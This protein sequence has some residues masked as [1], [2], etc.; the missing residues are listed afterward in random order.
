MPLVFKKS[1]RDRVDNITVLVDDKT[2]SSPNYFRVS[3][4]PQI[5]TKGKNLIK[6]SGH[7]T[8]LKEDTQIFIDVRDSNGNP[9]YYEIPDYIEDDKSRVISIWVYHDK[10]DDNT[11]NG[12]A[13]IT[14]VGVA[15]NDVDG[16]PVPASYKNKLNV[17][18]QTKVNV[19]RDRSSTTPI[20]FN[21][22]GITPSLILSESIESYQNQPQSGNDLDLTVQEGKVRYIF[23]GKTPIV[24]ITDGTTFNQE[25]QDSSILLSNFTTPATP[26]SKEEPT[27]LNFFSG[28]IKR[29][30]NTTTIQ[31]NN[32]YTA[33]FQNR[34]GLKHTYDSV[35][36]SDYKIEYFRTSSNVSTENQRS[37]VN[38]SFNNVDPIVGVVDKIKVLQKS[39]GL[40]GEFELLNEVAVPF[41]S[42]FSVKIPMP[43]EN[44]QDPKLLK[45]QYLNSIGEI[46]R[47]ETNIGPF[48][49]QGGNSYIGGSQNLISGS[50]FVS[51]TVGT[52]IELGGASSGFMRSVGFEGQTSA[53]L[54]KAPGGFVIYSGSGNLQM[55][56]DT[57]EGVGMQFIGDNDERHLIFTTANGGL[58]DVKT[59]KFFIGTEN[60]QFISGSD[61]NIE[62]SSSLFH[63]DP[64]NNLLTIG[65]DA[66][67][68]AGLSADRIFTPAIID[69][70]PSNINNASS[71]ITQD[72]FA[73]FTSA[74]IAGF[75]VNESEIKSADE[76]LRLKADGNITASKVLLQGGT[77]TD[78]VTILGSVSANSIQTP[79]TIGGNPST[80]GN[81]S[82]SI[83]DQGFASFKSA[84]IGGWDITPNTIQ[85]SNLVMRPAGILQT[86]DF[87]SGVKGWKISSEGNGTAEFEN[88]R[89]RGT[90][91]TTTFEKESVNAVGGQLWVTNA[92][93]LTGSNITST[94]T[95]MSVK[96][97]SGFAVG[98]ILLAKKVDGTGFQTEYLL[99]ESASIDGDNSG[100]EEVHGRIYV[101][102]AYGSGQQGEFVGDLASSAQTYDEGQVIV[103]TGLSGSGYIKMNANPKDTATPYMDIVERTGSG[104]FDAQLKVRLGDLSG[105]ANSD[106]VFG[107]PNPG[108]GLATD[109]V[110]L[111]G[112]IIANTGSIAGIKMTDGKLF[113]GNGSYGNSNTGFYVDSD[114]QFSLGN[115]LVWNPTTE[116]LVIRGQLQLSDGSDVGSALAEATS[117]NTSKTVSLGASSY[118]ITFNSLGNQDPAGQSITLTATEQ[119]HVG[120][121]Y[122]EFRKGGSLQGARGTSNTFVADQ[123]SE[124]PSAT[125][126]VTYEVKTFEVASGGSQI[127]S[128]TLTLFGVQAGASGSDGTSGQDGVDAVTAFLT[129]EAHT[130]AA[131][132]DKSIVSLTGGSTD[133][134]V[135]EGI[136]DKTTSYSYSRSSSTSVSSSISSNTVTVTSMAHDSGSI[137][138]TATSAST[139]LSKTMS[140]SKAIAGQT[141]SDGTDGTDGTDGLDGTSAKT[142]VAS[143]DSQ[144]MA[145]DDSSDTSATPTEVVFSFNQQNLNAAIGSSDITISTAGG[146][147]TNFGFDNNSVT[148]SSGKHSGISSGSIS[149]TGALNSGGLNSTKSNFPV[150]IS[151]TKDGLSDSIKLF[152]VE[153]GADGTAGADGTDAV[154]T[155]LTNESHTFTA[156]SDGTIISFIGGSTDMEV[157]EGVT[158][159][160]ANYTISS[161][162]GLGVT[163]TDSGKTVTISGMTH[164]SGSVTITA[165][166]AS[167]SLSKSMSLTKSKQGTAGLA[168]SDA[169][170][171]TVSSDSQVFSFPS[172][173]SSTAI[174][175]DILITINQQNLSGTVGGGDFTIV[176]A[177]GSTLSDP[178]L[179]ASV[180]D[181]SGQVTGTITFSGTASGDKTKLPLTITVSKDSLED[182][183]KIFGIDGGNEGQDGAAGADAVT[184][185]LTNESHTF[186][187]DSSGSIASFVGGSTNMEIFEGI[188]NK[189]SLYTI[190]SS[191]SLGVTA[192]DNSNTVTIGGMNH[193]SGSVTITAT[194]ASVSLSKIMSLTKARQ[195]SDGSD[196]TSAK[197]LIGS[198]DSQVFAFTDSTDTTSEPEKVFFSYQQQNLSAAIV[199][200]DLTITTAGGSNITNFDF[201]NSDISSGTGIVSGSIVFSQALN[202]GGVAGTKSN[203][204]ITVS[205]TKDGLQDS[206]RVFKVE[207]GSDGTDGESARTMI[208]TNESHTFA[209]QPNGTIISFTGG[210]TDVEVFTGTSNTTSDYSISAAS[211]TS[212]SSSVSS[213]TVTV[214]SMG[215]D[216]GSVVVTATSAS[217]NLQKLFSLTKAKQGADGEDGASGDKFADTSIS[218]TINLSTLNIDDTITFTADTGL[219]WTAGLTAVVAYDGSNSITG[220]VNSYNS[221]NGSM[222]INVDSIVG[223][224][225]QTAWTLNLGGTAGPQGVSGVSAKS[226]VAST[227]S[228]V[229]SFL[230]ASDSTAE[231]TSIIFSFNQQNLNDSIGSSDVTITAGDGTN[232]TGF[233]F[234]NNSVTDGTG[235][236]SGS[237]S[238]SSG[239]SAGGLNSDKTKLPVTISVTNDS[240]TD[241]IKVFKVEGGTSGTDGTDGSDAVTTFLTNEAHTFA[242]QNDGTIV[243][244][245]GAQTDMEVFEGVTNKTSV[246]TFSKSDGLGVTS[247]ITG[248]TVT[249]S[250]MTHDSG[251]VTITAVSASTSLSKTMSLVKSKQGTAGLAGADAKLLTITS[252]SQVFAF[253]SASSSTP[254][255]NDILLIINQQNLSGTIGGSDIT[256]K[257][258]GGN[259][260][261]DPTFVA[262]VTDG[263]GQVS[264]SITFSG[265]GST[266]GGVKTKLPLTIEVAKDSLEDSLKIFK[267]DGGNEGQ[268]GADAVTAF[269][270]NEAHTF[271][272]DS[273]GAIASFVGATTDMEV[274]EGIT[275]KTS[276]Y[277][278]SKTDGT[279]VTSSASGKTIT[280]SGMTHDSGSITVN[281]A[282]GSVSINKTMS[283]VKSRQG[284]DGSDGTSAKLLIGS[285]D[286]QVISFDDIADTTAT[287][288][289][290]EFSFQQQNLSGSAGYITLQSGDITIATNGGG[291]I[292]N[293][294]FN[295][296]NVTNGTGISSG[297]ISFTAATNAGGM[298]S[299]K[300]KFPVTISAT[301]DGLQDAVKLF[302]VEGGADGADSV[303]VLLSND[304]HTLAA[305]SNGDII[306]FT[307]ADTDVTVF[308]GIADKTSAYTIS[309]TN[310][311]GVSTTLSGDN[312]AVTAMTHD[313]G[314]VTIN[315]SSGS[316]SIDKLMSITKAKQGADGDKFADTSIT[317]TIN[318]TTVSEDDTL[319]FTADTGLAWTAGLTAVLSYDSSN[320]INGTV[321][322]YN[323]A[324]GAMSLNVDTITGGGSYTAWSLNVG[325]VAGPQGLSGA[326]AKN[327]VASVDSQ[328][329][330]FLSASDT[331]SNPTD[332][333]FSFNQ[334]NLN[335]ATIGSGDITITGADSTNITG[336]SLDTNDVDSN[337]SG[338]VSG[339]LSFSAATN[340]GGLNSD[341]AKLPVTI[342]VTKDGLTDSVSVFKIEGGSDGVNG[343]DAVTAFLTNEAHTFASAN[344]GTI[345]SFN[346][347]F[348]D[349]EVFEGTT[350]KNSEYTISKVDGTGVT[351]AVSGK[352]VTISGLTHDS[353]SVIITATSASGVS[354]HEVVLN[355]TMS[356]VKSKQGAVGLAGD[357]AKMLTIT[358][359]S[360]VFSFP[361]SSSSTAIDNT[362][363][364]VINQQNL[365]ATVSTSDLV[366]KDAGGN[367]LTNPTLAPS[368]LTN[369]TGLVSGSITF[370][371]AGSPGGGGTVNGD[372]TKLPLEIT[373]TQDGLTDSLKIFKVEGGTGGTNGSNGTDA[374]NGFLSNESHTFPADFSG[375]IA[376][377]DGGTTTMSV[378]EGV[379]DKTSAY[380]YT[381]SDGTGVTS[382]LGGSN[383][384]VLTI[385]ALT[386]DSGSVS[387]TAA[388]SSVS[389]SKTMSLTKSRQG[390]D[391]SDGTSAKLLVGSLNSQ[392]FAFDDSADNIS[393]PSSVEFSFNQQNLSGTIGTGDITITTANSNTVTNYSFDNND[394]ANGTGI[395]S[396]SVTY[397]ASFTSG[398]ANQLKASLPITITATKDG[399]SDSVKIFKVEGGANGTNGASAVTA[400]LTNDSHTLPVSSSDT[401]ISYA[402]ASTDIIVFQGTSDVTNDYTISRTS[403]SHI[404]TTLS[405]DTV[406]ITESTTPF[407]GSVVVTA[408]SA[409]GVSGHEVSLSKTLS[410][411]QA[412]QGD[413]GDDGAPGDNAKTVA[414]GAASQIFVKSQS[415]TLS[416]ASIVITANGQN[417][418]AAGAWSTTAGTLTND[419]T[420]SSGGSATITNNNFVDNMV[421]TYTA[422]SNDGSIT[423]SVTIKELDEGSGAVSA[424]L[425]NESHVVPAS[426]AG[427][428]SSYTNSGTSIDVY[429]GATQLDYDGSGTTNGHWTIGTPTVSP[430]S[431]ITVGSISD[432]TNTAVVADH[433]SM[434]NGIDSVTIT[435]PITGKTQNGTEFS[436]NKTQTITKSKEGAD[437]APGDNAKLLSISAASQ[438][439]AFDDNL[440]ETATPSTIAISVNAQ[441]IT[442]TVT[443]SD[444]TITKNGGGTINVPT[445]SSGEFDLTFDNG[446][447]AAD[448]KVVDKDHLP[449]T[450]TVSKD[451]QSDTITIFKVEG[452]LAGTPGA[453][454]YTVFLTNESHTFPAAAD[455]TV[456]SG[457][458]AAGATEVRVFKG[459]TQLTNDNSSPYGANTYR[460]AK[461]NTGIT[462][463]PSVSNSQRKFT[464]TGVTADNGTATITI[465]DNTTGTAFTKTYSFSK[466]K[467]GAVGAEGSNSKTVALT[468]ATNV[469]TYEADGGSPSPSSTITLSA[470]SQNFTNGYFKFTGDGITEETSYTDGSSANGDTK[471]FDVPTNYFSTPKTI[472]VGVSEANQ[473]EL[474]FDTV[475]IVAVQPGVAGSAGSDAVT[476]FLTSEADV[477]PAAADGTVSSFAGSG[478]EM[479]IY[480]GITN[481]ST[482]YTV[483][484]TNSSG[485]TST[486]SGRT[487]SITGLTPDSGSVILTAASGGVSLSK[488]YSIGKSKAGAQGANNQDFSFLDANL[489]AVQGTLAAGL[490]MNSDV[491]GYHGAIGNGV[492]AALSDFTSFLDKD[493]NFYLGG[494][495]SGATNPS[496]G[497]FAWNNSAKSLL[498]SGSKAQVEVDKFFLGNVGTQFISGSDGNI[499]ISGDVEFEGRNSN[500]ATVYYDNFA[501]Y[502]NGA[503]VIPA[504]SPQVDGSGVGYYKSGA[505]EV[506]TINT[507]SNV[508]GYSGKVLRLGNNSSNDYVYLTGNKLIPFNENSLYEIE[509]RYKIEIGSGTVYAGIVGF[510]SDGTT[511]VNNAG[512]DT[513]SGQHYIAVSGQGS[514]VSGNGW[515]IRKGYFKGHA[516]T[517]TVGGQHNSDTD[518]AVLHSNVVN[519]YITPMFLAN[520]NGVAGKVL[521]DYIKITEIGGGGSTKISGDTITTGV[522]KSNNLATDEGSEFRLD[523]G[524]FKL[525][526]TD[527]AHTKLEWDG[528]DL[529]VKGNITVTNAGDFADPAL[530]ND[531]P[532]SSNLYAHYP[533]HGKVISNNG[534]DRILDFSGNERH[535]DDTAD[536][537][538]YGTEFHSGSDAGPLPGA[539]R[540]GGYD[541][542]VEL[543]TLAQGLTNNMD[544]SL[545]FWIKKTNT[546]QSAVFGIHDGG[547]NDLVFFVDEGAVGNRV[548]LICG[549]DLGVINT[550]VEF[551]NTWRH[552]GLVMDNGVAGK[553]YIDGVFIG[554]FPTST[555]NTGDFSNSDEMIFGGELDAA[556]GAPTD[557]W[558]GYLGEFRIY[559]SVLTA[560]NMQALYNLPTGIPSSTN[561]SGDQISTGKLKSSNWSTTLG[562]NFDLDGGTFK[563]GG[564]SNP[565]LEF[566]GTTLSVKG[567]IEVQGGGFNSTAGELFANPT[568]HLLA[569]DG[570]PGGWRCAYA[571]PSLTN[572]KSTDL[573]DGNGKIVEFS[574]TDGIATHGI[575]SHALPIEVQ[576]NYKIKLAVKAS[577]AASSGFYVR[578]YEYDQELGIL[579]DGTQEHSVSHNAHNSE[580]GTVEDTRLATAANY[581]ASDKWT[582]DNGN[583]V[584]EENGPLTTSY[585]NYNATYIPTATAKYF[586]IV[587]LHWTNMAAATKIYV[588]SLNIRK[589]SQGTTI[590][591]EGISTG[592]IV[593]ANLDANVGS[594][595]DL[596]AGTIKLGGTSAP[597][598]AVNEAGA[599][600]ASAGLIGG[601]EIQDSYVEST[602]D[603]SIGGPAYKLTDDGIISGSNIYIRSVVDV[604]NGDEVYPILDT[605]VGLI[606]ARN[607]GRQVV[608]DNNQYYRLNGDDNGS[609]Y[610]VASYVFHLMPYETTLSVSGIHTAYTDSYSTY[611]RLSGQLDVRLL[612]MSVSGSSAISSNS[613]ASSPG[614]VV[615]TTGWQ[616]VS[617][618]ITSNAFTTGNTTTTNRAMTKVLHG[619]NSIAYSVP[620][621]AQAQLCK[622]E[623]KIGTNYLYNAPTIN[624]YVSANAGCMVQGFSVIATR[625]LAAA[626]IGSNSVSLMPTERSFAP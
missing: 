1:F 153:G 452:G 200:G 136:T 567:N 620:A 540:F 243:S 26:K 285:L 19:D 235:I 62:I 402:G 538:T 2:S 174:D 551:T 59:D 550:G 210:D 295:N 398:G 468:A 263:T 458:L 324:N 143:I 419:S 16:L 343:T 598:F 205:A 372:K 595:L 37:F 102:R 352:R 344:D 172:A 546:T 328:V 148:N 198:L 363:E 338:I 510:Q 559:D 92:T 131:N 564:S 201:N 115:K 605:E 134:I 237:I 525:G 335:N 7:P 188:T 126:P 568:G 333:I 189:T 439:F 617:A 532:D 386:H 358:S 612:R 610:L 99:I 281:A 390:G 495:S 336:F 375:S 487:L 531:F 33:S 108:F 265:M 152:K 260:L 186:P 362:I 430:T 133:M 337:F 4:V 556:N 575:V 395:V 552:I 334:Q 129:N 326:N 82:S 160:T 404:T 72:G 301:K 191:V 366:I 414:V 380:S 86:R 557:D 421:V 154:T 584:N 457:V 76:S 67:I 493:G 149:F 258:S 389:L 405:G 424:L 314:S 616:Q 353:G 583:A 448:G 244:F 555:C 526:G 182:S 606:D 455:G 469:I 238:F 499:R 38:I 364:L 279:G 224:S 181:G 74:S 454:A 241:S 582:Y 553:L 101:Q 54:G 449:L 618:D 376:S 287:P 166:S 471:S 139:S 239:T 463:S 601:I 443:K 245:S 111:Q 68:K 442:G 18:W 288:T 124:Q 462:L 150:A 118:V 504:N 60:S 373:I 519:G 96:N 498:I 226:L 202:N 266:V 509:F 159:S 408:V 51:N 246:Y 589:V 407:S 184:T 619:E 79:A 602:N 275:N 17:R 423:D 479:F 603:L 300:S 296:N 597:K 196:G 317:T 303:S 323:S 207:G 110:F 310:G 426:S 596:D 22:N 23:K 69:G 249:V 45:I 222:S 492:T 106:Y 212:V 41:S 250:G 339:S 527:A 600:T 400:L 117:S 576:Q 517:G 227:D 573:N 49:F 322:S 569:S 501:S 450:I 180:T 185:F 401:V 194:S 78:N 63:L 123:S 262:S 192:T 545:S 418:T 277:T 611:A 9:I 179:S 290:I 331:T 93:T 453:D 561:I 220:T 599:M 506:T 313:S 294:D 158:N 144:V 329:F 66:V 57:L 433:S 321:N 83:T 208:L 56:A 461:T 289:S 147:V 53:S 515:V 382:T 371:P 470:N 151:I 113:T 132:P 268:D 247:S 585:V 604:G 173:S 169:K 383:G 476:T 233:G 417:L 325:G 447:S 84:S 365:S 543:H 242:S 494:N 142:L 15:N 623:L 496:D 157:F 130:F 284:G 521:L 40:P 308:E 304:S 25:M 204:P 29:V 513:L 190:S 125:T 594:E 467:E 502:A 456:D 354:G 252:D 229:F 410:V 529:S 183:I 330:S 43:S 140:L 483:T 539:I 89:I 420:T 50:I 422:H 507:P 119:N 261:T 162:R 156:E 500:G 466:S 272:A 293:F 309:R 34:E 503:A 73:K 311:T 264:G 137:I 572:L 384:N 549:N 490:L 472:R 436:F 535:G 547:G 537:I 27:N 221:S 534:Y 581:A 230:S 608:G 511:Y 392:V 327:I 548:K 403:D 544:I 146:N 570:R 164:D 593:S 397:G 508:G 98:E 591:G 145:F 87:A 347:A 350:N 441:N 85:G 168:G 356:L 215:H 35:E 193:D 473:T 396:G 444:I 5:L 416:P 109:N 361:S 298:G 563:L 138:I 440:D 203:L 286:S 367:T 566:D 474:T 253:P 370:G 377:F 475:T 621:S 270:T 280:I 65:A 283:L 460:A 588:K 381:K 393:T 55:G 20:I 451:S 231:P 577:A 574:R 523:D 3:D 399:L 219:A 378:F 103:S 70:A 199:A 232:I 578:I 465:T 171:L 587:L 175:N 28:S 497:Y 332:I 482:A 163:A 218:T 486:L 522:I 346:G 75:T 379:T 234:D 481:K 248:K 256:I 291:N 530:V 306:S 299:D 257:D 409:S 31:L 114:S 213:N 590:T 88:I 429:E 536:G 64:K 42:S 360:P 571:Y 579:N 216:S 411:S 170:I 13:T 211:T 267:I 127:A 477:V 271:A 438:T 554:N 505:G 161:S 36:E 524:T 6:I 48:V 225:T 122:Y 427:V 302:K 374:V 44:L 32:P 90:L 613:L 491:F 315:A 355:K 348:T 8:N 197:L 622:I 236:A 107:N 100:A 558:I 223:T 21:S 269:L 254:E 178:T 385:S 112:G 251:S 47:T 312:I 480:E 431:K 484:K 464:P 176:D 46:S 542:R 97:A 318:L 609:T 274:F 432:S 52:G 615:G 359:D 489:S 116:A 14:L 445:L 412:L 24:Q 10:G 351:S 305:Y 349:M 278:I 80:V 434:N 217:V 514:S 320:F 307:G 586:S 342:S 273:T 297:S 528:T 206:V 282:S 135:F 177:N 165:T 520:Y 12:E 580:D 541:G 518:P 209:A 512:T 214:T 94:Q 195:G 357:D 319:T 388:S 428:V 292:T 415:G 614:Q 155:F 187:A 624:S 345:V 368:S 485:L 71:S 120:T 435:Y 387:I 259:T 61:S 340:A 369:N 341:K 516:S 626:S 459:T 95:T 39:D 128:D 533:L 141:G 316:V 255:D 425:T 121:V 560:A 167:V 228:Q 565:K 240:L 607:N 478:T 77:I 30:T 91:R 406:T 81:A 11:P 625:E 562:S 391:G 394:V 437:G 413:D 592:K 58:L 488:T 446:A 105:L 276:V 104:L